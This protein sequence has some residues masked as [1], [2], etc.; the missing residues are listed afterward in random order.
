MEA[1]WFYDLLYI[2]STFVDMAFKVGVL[3]YLSEY[4]EMR[5]RKQ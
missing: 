5:G 2:I 4:I 1:H 3:Y